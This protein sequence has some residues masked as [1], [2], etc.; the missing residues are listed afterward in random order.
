MAADT[1][2]KVKILLE[3][4][5]DSVESAL[6]A[7]RGGADRLEVCGNLGFGGGTTPSIGLLRSIQ[8]ATPGIPIMAMVRPR[9]GDFLYSTSEIEVMLEDIRA[10]KRHSV[11]GVV[12]GVL[13]EEGSI[14]VEKTKLLVGEASPLEVCFHRAFDLTGDV[15]RAFGDILSISGITRILTSGQGVSA[16]ASLEVLASLMQSAKSQSETPGLRQLRILPGSGINASS[17][18][19]V[20]DV[21]LPQGLR[22]VHL[23]GGQW[24]DGN[25]AFRPGGMG[26]GAGGD[27]EWAIWR[28]SEESVQAVRTFLDS[29]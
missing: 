20:C 23:S 5:V 24:I 17:I 8:S 3:V 18:K 15:Y 19:K 16:P 29:L 25:M 11:Q 21:L 10:F 4:C 9:V 28:T 13:T 26:M 27:R 6:A 7:V 22:E 12:F 14:D 2:S 1:T